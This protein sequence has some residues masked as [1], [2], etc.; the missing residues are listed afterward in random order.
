MSGSL[1]A[2][3][4]SGTVVSEL[5][6]AAAEGRAADP[7]AEAFRPWPTERRRTLWPT[8]DSGYIYSRHQLVGLDVAMSFV[9][10]LKSKREGERTVVWEPEEPGRPNAMTRAALRSWRSLAVVLSALDTYYWPFITHTV[11]HN[12]AAWRQARQTFEPGDMITWLGITADQVEA[13]AS[14]LRI[15]AAFRDDMGEFYDLVRR[16][17]VSTRER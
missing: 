9:S 6:R 16:A 7:A 14:D 13:Q 4:V 5:L 17:S 11:S 8:Y 15:A 1:A 10:A 12:M 3:N 2:Q